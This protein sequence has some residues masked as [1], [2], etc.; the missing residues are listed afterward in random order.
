[1]VSK[2]G[3]VNLDNYDND[4]GLKV[5]T[6]GMKISVITL[7]FNLISKSMTIFIPIRYLYPNLQL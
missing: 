6:S 3:F 7:V 2:P 1:M 4:K 5:K